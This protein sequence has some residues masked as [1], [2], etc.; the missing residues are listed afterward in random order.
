MSTALLVRRSAVVAAPPSAVFELLADAR[1]HIT[2]DGSGTLVDVLD[3]PERLTLGAEFAVRMKAGARYTVHNVVVEFEPD[4]RIAWRHRARHVWRW[5][6]AAVAGGTRVTESWD[7]WAKRG[8]RLVA[9]IGMPRNAGAAIDA[10]L[11]GLQA[12]FAV[13]VSC[14]PG[15]RAV[16]KSLRHDVDPG[17]SGTSR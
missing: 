8:P 1:Q 14:Q 7:G 11:A 2:L 16:G 12:R 17:M 9:A 5:E 6:L 4:V 13:P 15:Q 3:A 10:T